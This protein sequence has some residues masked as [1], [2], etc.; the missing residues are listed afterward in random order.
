MWSSFSTIAGSYRVP[1]RDGPGDVTSSNTKISRIVYMS[2]DCGITW[3]YLGHKYPN[4]EC[5]M[6]CIGN[7]AEIIRYIDSLWSF[8]IMP[9]LYSEG[10]SIEVIDYIITFLK[11][12]P[13][14]FTG[15]PLE[16]IN[17]IIKSSWSERSESDSAPVIGPRTTL[18]KIGYIVDEN[19]HI[20]RIGPYSTVGCLYTLEALGFDPLKNFAVEIPQLLVLVGQPGSGKSTIASRL[21]GLGWYVVNETQAASIRRAT[22]SKRSK[23]IDNFRSIVAAIGR[24]GTGHLGVVIDCTNPKREHRALYIGFAEQAGVPYSV[25]WIT[26]PGFFYN[27]ERPL[28]IPE[29][30]LRVYARNLEP[31]TVEEHA[32]RLI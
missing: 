30:A 8:G 6:W 18:P 26:R 14:A 19:P 32:F 16:T 2:L 31:P 4:T 24:T 23:I 3:N 9:V 1:R 12:E 29:E 17:S 11:T 28:K 25:G 7:E 15:M 5:W 27:A 10:A 13:L 20:Y 21:G 22:S